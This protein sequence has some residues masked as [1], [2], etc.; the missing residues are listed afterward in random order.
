LADGYGSTQTATSDKVRGDRT[1]RKFLLIW[2]SFNYREVVTKKSYTIM[3]LF[4]EK[5]R[6][7]IKA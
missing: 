5:I 2:D 3:I 7:A 6:V 4:G 1:Q